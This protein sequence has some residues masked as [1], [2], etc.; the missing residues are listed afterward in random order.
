MTVDVLPPYDELPELGNLGVRHSWGL[1]PEE[2]G[3][4]ALIGPDQIRRATDTVTEGRVFALS[5][6]IATFDQPLFGRDALNHSV[7]EAGRNELE[8]VFDRLNPQAYS[9]IDGLAHVRAREYGFYGGHVDADEARERLG[10][11]HW[12]AHP[13]AGRGVLLDVHRSRRE[14]GHV[15]DPM[16]GAAVLPSELELVAKEQDV[17]LERGDIVLVHTGWLEAFRRQPADTP[18]TAWNGLHAGEATAQYLWDHR[19]A[20]LGADNPAVEDAPGSREAGSLH[21]RLLPALGL[22][23]ME[24]LRL[25]ELAQVCHDIGRWEF[26]FTAA[27]LPVHGAVSSPANALALL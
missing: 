23:L 9:Q 11:H 25:D 10:M 1:L 17:A 21:R 20:L 19:V 16:A 5:E 15:D 24:L 6:P 26:L 4:L 18:V 14:R 13:I 2:A 12:A 3:T 22:S 7:I 27:P 8:D